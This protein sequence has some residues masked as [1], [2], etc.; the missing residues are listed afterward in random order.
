MFR[1]VAPGFS[2]FIVLI[3]FAFCTLFPIKAFSHSGGLNASGCH[4]GSKPYHCHRSASS[5][6]V[7]DGNGGAMLASSEI[8]DGNNRAMLAA[9]KSVADP[10][11]EAITILDLFCFISKYWV[12]FKKYESL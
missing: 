12:E 1:A 2:L 4:A 11:G 5:K 3:V 6:S 7:D 10:N 9:S 8:E